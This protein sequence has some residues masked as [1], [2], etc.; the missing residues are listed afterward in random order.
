VDRVLKEFSTRG[1]DEAKVIGS[2]K[3]GAA[4]IKVI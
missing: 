4:A 3:A 2:L 1:F